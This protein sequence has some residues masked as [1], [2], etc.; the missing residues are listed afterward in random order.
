MQS[1]TLNGSAWNNAYLPASFMTGG[2]TLAFTLGTTANTSWATGTSAAP[3][4]YPGAGGTGTVTAPV[5]GQE[6]GRC[7]DV[8]G[9]NQT[10]GT[11]PALW[12]CNGGTNQSWTATTGKQLM[13]FGTKCLDV[14]AHGTTD[15]A[16]VQIWDCTGGTNQ[17]WTVN[18]DGTIVGAESGKCLDATGHG[19]ANGTLLAI[20]TCTG[21]A[22]Q[23]WTHS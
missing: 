22:N 15:G 18:A 12:D 8:P 4:S 7:V 10:N 23:K 19:T 3:P 5:R 9:A 6:S 1:A 13:V 14:N 17:Q 2:G 11:R 21:G 16:T 20:W